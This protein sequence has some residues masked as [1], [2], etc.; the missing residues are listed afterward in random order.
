MNYELCKK[1]KEAGF[2][3]IFH[4][5]NQYEMDG[6]LDEEINNGGRVATPTLSELISECGEIILFYSDG[7]TM[8]ESGWYAVE[9][10]LGLDQN[11]VPELSKRITTNGKTPEISVAN[12]F[13]K[14][15]GN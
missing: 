12:L 7:D 14:L 11:Y 10:S 4:Y 8:R 15:N 13:L 9:G 6:Y 2:P 3:Q 1:L 5:K